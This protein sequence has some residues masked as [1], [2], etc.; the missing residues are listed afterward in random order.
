MLQCVAVCCSVLQC[1]AV[2]RTDTFSG[3]LPTKREYI[4]QR[5][6]HSVVPCVAV[7]CSMLQCYINVLNA[8]AQDVCVCVCV[9]VCVCVCVCVCV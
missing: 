4:T 9:H 6:L 7:F 2:S 1:V 3:K 8:A 5:M